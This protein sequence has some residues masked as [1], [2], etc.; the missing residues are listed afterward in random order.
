VTTAPDVLAFAEDARAL[1]ALGPDE[2]RIDL[3]S[4]VITCAPGAHYWSTGVARIRF[5]DDVDA[6]LAGVRD[7]I[8]ARSRTSAGWTIGGS[9]TPAGVVDRLLGLGLESEPGPSSLAMV[10]DRPPPSRDTPF[11][12]VEVRRLEELRAAIE[13]ANAGFDHPTEDGADERHRAADTFA[14]ERAGG[15]TFRLLV[16]DGDEPVA[17]GQA[18]IGPGG[19][20]LGGGATLPEHRRRGAMSALVAAAWDAAVDRGTPALVAYGNAMSAPTLARLGFRAI[21][22][23]RHLVDR[24]I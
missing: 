7:A 3:G 11:R 20:Y 22:R 17:T 24:S 23:V 16:L 5:G 9:A 8:R 21:G 18:W 12:I 10:L 15:H 4:A 2:E 1:V 13:V 19:L 14:R 6:A